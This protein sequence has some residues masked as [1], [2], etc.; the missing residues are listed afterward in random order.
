MGGVEPYIAG[1]FEPLD[2]TTV[3]TPLA[4]DRVALSACRQWAVANPLASQD[5][6]VLRATVDTLYKR[7]LARVPTEAETGHLIGLYNDIVLSGKPQPERSWTTLSCFA[8]ATT[9]EALFY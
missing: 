8:V 4:V 6:A 7:L 5:E 9:M 1:I 2:N 3:S